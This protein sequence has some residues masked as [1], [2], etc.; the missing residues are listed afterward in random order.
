MIFGG[1]PMAGEAVTQQT[2]HQKQTTTPEAVPVE[3]APQSTGVQPIQQLQRLVGNQRTNY[4]IANPT[5]AMNPS[6]LVRRAPGLP[7]VRGLVQRDDA[8]AE[9]PAALRDNRSSAASAYAAVPLTAIA[10]SDDEIQQAIQFNRQRFPPESVSALRRYFEQPDGTE[11]DADMIRAIARYQQHFNLGTDGKIG[12]TTYDHIDIHQL[13]ETAVSGTPTPESDLIFSIN[14]ERQGER[15]DY[16]PTPGHAGMMTFRAI[17]RFSVDVLFPQ[18]A[19]P[20]Q[21]RYRQMIK[22]RFVAVRGTTERN[23]ARSFNRIPV[24]RRLPA[25]YTE[26]GNTDWGSAGIFYGRREDEGQ[27]TATG[28]RG[29]NQYFDAHGSPDQDRGHRYRATD[30]PSAELT[31]LAPGTTLRLNMEFLGQI[32]RLSDDTVVQEKHWVA[33]DYEDIVP[34]TADSS[35][36]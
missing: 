3:E 28:T 31:G 4:L 2:Q 33:F 1:M 13:L 7:P 8:P 6:A 25:D 36:A 21:Y 14:V 9:L 16:N 32:V 30:G 34:N 22:G 11:F 26:D 35:G 24:T 17:S 20:E 10:L 29:Q 5:P 12:E 19:R 18:H 15:W 27:P 23:W